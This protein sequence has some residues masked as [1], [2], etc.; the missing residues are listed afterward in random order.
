MVGRFDSRF[1]GIRP[2]LKGCS[3]LG[4]GQCVLH[5]AM[6]FDVCSDKLV[7]PELLCHAHGTRWS[8]VAIWQEM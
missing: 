2:L 8:M 5:R 4:S 6:Q 1:V 7:R 3:T